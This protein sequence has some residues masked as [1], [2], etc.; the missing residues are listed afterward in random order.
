MSEPSVVPDDPATADVSEP[1]ADAAPAGDAS[2]A[3]AATSEAPA[4]AT[5]DPATAAVGDPAADAAAAGGASEAPSD[6]AAAGPAAPVMESTWLERS[7]ARKA[8]LK[9]IQAR[10]KTELGEKVSANA[11]ERMAYLMRQ[12]DVFAHF[13]GKSPDEVGGAAGTSADGEGGGGGADAAAGRRTKGRLTEKQ[14]DE[15]LLKAAE[16]DAGEKAGASAGT[17]LSVQPKCVTGTMRA[18]QLE[19]LNWLIK[20]YEH[21]IN[22]ILADEMGLGKTLQTISLLG[23]LKEVKV[24]YCYSTV[25]TVFSQQPPHTNSFTFFFLTQ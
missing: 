7:R 22:G 11:K 8:A 17:R 1:A 19:G 16:T 10:E 25:Q 18:Y 20:L 5:G 21:G 23:Y 3:P 6:A 4:A 2:E 9:T 12:T 24:G 13:M 14:E 15:L